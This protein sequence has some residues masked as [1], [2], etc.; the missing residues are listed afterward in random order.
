MRR[1]LSNLP[2]ALLAAL[3]LAGPAA[4]AQDDPGMSMFNSFNQ[5]AVNISLND[6]N[7]AAVMAAGR[8][9]TAG[10][11]GFD[12]LYPGSHRV[13]LAYTPTAAL[14]KQIVQKRISQAQASNPAYAQTLTNA[15]GPGK[16][17]YD[18]LF[19]KII[20]GSGLPANNAATAL[21]TYLELGY[22]IINNVQDDKSLTPAMDQGLQRQAAG[23]LSRNKSLTS[24]A[25]VAQMGEEVKLQAVLLY[26]GWQSVQKSGN[27]S[28]FRSS[29]A[30]QFK[31][32]GLDMSTLRLTKQGLV[33]R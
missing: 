1:F 21:A 25:A 27:T 26:L 2:G 7:N 14:K 8:N 4:R 13:S 15:L 33:K 20:Q 24:A 28:Q 10:K 18:Q 5:M 12:N 32:K 6:V 11:P 19:E 22:A 3:L 23:I 29:I 31:Q 30:Q 16:A 9:A 17:D